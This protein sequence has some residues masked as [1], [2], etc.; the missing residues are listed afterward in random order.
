MGLIV[1]TEESFST[2]ISIAIVRCVLPIRKYNL[3]GARPYK[4]DDNAHI[5]QKNWT[6]VR[7]LI[8]YG[9]LD[10]PKVVE[11]LNDLYKREWNWFNNY[12]CPSMK[13]ISKKRVGSR[14]VK[15]YDS[16]KTPYQRVIECSDV[17][18]E[19][20]ER[21]REFSSRLNPFQLN[22]IIEQ[23]VADILDNARLP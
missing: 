18:Q 14:M 19:T 5:E 22:T 16:P 3:P 9:R 6:H 10:N 7:Q 11:L 13:L 15:V 1:I 23:K 4:K 17:P 8:G 12:Y 20:K 21:L 2:I